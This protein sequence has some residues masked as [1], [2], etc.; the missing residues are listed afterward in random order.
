MVAQYANDYRQQMEPELNTNVYIDT[1]N[2]TLSLLPGIESR[3][4]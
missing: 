4:L 2:S 3:P 1:I